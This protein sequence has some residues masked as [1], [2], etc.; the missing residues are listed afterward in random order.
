MY[1]IFALSALCTISRYQNVRFWHHFAKHFSHLRICGSYNSSDIAVLVTHTVSAPLCYFFSNQLVQWF[2]VDQLILKFSA[3]R[4]GC[5]HKNKKTFFVF[6]ADIDERIHPVRTKVWVH[7][8]KV[9]I[10][11]NVLFASHFNASQ[12]SHCIRCGSRTDISTFDISDHHQIFGFT[13]IHCLFERLDSR[14]SEL[15]IHRDLRLH[16]RNQIICLVHNL[17]VKLPDCFCR[18][19]QCLSEFSKCF[20][21]HVLRNVV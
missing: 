16:C 12:M 6:F 4:I 2:S 1:Q 13:V 17:F 19:F 14:N 5:L 9:L 20:F 10:K 11:W 8:C 15:L 18:P 21:L 3:G 7:C